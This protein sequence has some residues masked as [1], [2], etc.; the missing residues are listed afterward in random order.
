MKSVRSLV[1]LGTLFTCSICVFAQGVASKKVVEQTVK[2]GIIT[3]YALDPLAQSFCFRDAGNGHVFQQHEV[4]N[5]CSD[6]NYNSYNAEQFAVGIEGGRLGSIVD[7]GSTEDLKKEYGY[8]E[9]VGGGQ[10]FASVHL[11]DGKVVILQDRAER[12]MQDLKESTQLFAQPAAVAIAPVKIGHVYMARITDRFDSS[13]QLLVKLLVIG[14]A[15]G[16]S[17]TFRWQTL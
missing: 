7:L 15:P 10:G 1:V 5:R 2:G 17:V 8:E 14:H 6:I 4:R 13:F 9:T 16:E 12:V 11:E 3:L